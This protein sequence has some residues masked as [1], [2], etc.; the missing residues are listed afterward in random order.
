MKARRCEADGRAGKG[1]ASRG[2]VPGPGKGTWEGGLLDKFTWSSS[3]WWQTPRHGPGKGW[4]RQRWEVAAAG[5]AKVEGLCR[6]GP[7]GGH[8]TYGNTG[9]SRVGKGWG[10]R[11]T[12]WLG[13]EG[14]SGT[15]GW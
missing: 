6:E 9:Q 2:L 13:E 3:G 10:A 12:A 4:L 15:P 11:S 5:M 1:G 8:Q 14:S 7:G